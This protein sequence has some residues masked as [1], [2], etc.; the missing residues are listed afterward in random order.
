M[1]LTLLKCLIL[2]ITTFSHQSFAENNF[3]GTQWG[4]S[5]NDVEALESNTKIDTGHENI[6]GYQGTVTGLDCYIIYYFFDNKLTK[7]RYTFIEKHY[8]KN[9]Y[10]MD[11]NTTIEN[12][13]KK[14]GE[15][16]ENETA[17]LN[18]LYKDKPED[19]GMAVS[20]GHLARYAAW[21]TKDTTIN[22]SL[23][24]DN[25]KVSMLLEYASKEL[26]HL[27]IKAKN[28]RQAA[29]L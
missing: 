6:L 23:S 25:F 17:W 8:N 3:R 9:G 5:K 11:Y 4:M 19:W 27:E 20:I 7:G 28:E 26:K 22:I 1:K 14:Y 2:L 18:S 10:L 15:P 21:E 13:S 12:L 29:E 16:P 24:G